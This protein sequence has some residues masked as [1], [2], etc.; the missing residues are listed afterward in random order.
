MRFATGVRLA[1]ILLF[2]VCALQ[3]TRFRTETAITQ[4]LPEGESRDKMALAGLIRATSFTRGMILDVQLPEGGESDAAVAFSDR[5]A[6]SLM[7]SGLFVGVTN[8]ADE[9]TAE[10]FHGIYFPRRYGLLADQPEQEIG[11]LFGDEGLTRSMRT[12]RDQ[13][14]LPSGLMLKRLADD[15]PTLAFPAL[16]Q[17]LE[18]L[19]ARTAP[20]IHCGRFFSPDHHHLLLLA[21]TRA[22][23]FD[24][25]EQRRA[26]DT[27]HRSFDS[28]D[29][30]MGGGY[31]LTFTG[32]NRFALESETRIRRDVMWASIAATIGVLALFALFFRR[33]RLLLLCASPL[34]F[35]VVIA[36]GV[37]L[38]LFGAIHGLTLAFGTTLLGVC[39]DYP[40]H[41]LNHI[42]MRGEGSGHRRS[43]RR[44]H[45]SLA[46]GAVTTLAGYLVISLSSFPGVRQIAVFS[47]AGIV[48]AFAFTMAFVPPVA[49]SM[50][51]GEAPSLGGW[52]ARAGAWRSVGRARVALA[53]VLGLLALASGIAIGAIRAETDPLAFDVADPGTREADE[54]IRGRLPA[55]S[56]PLYVLA[57]GADAEEALQ[58]NEQL[59]RDLDDLVDAG[60]VAR[61]A[62]VRWLLPSRRLQ[63][64]NVQAIVA[65]DGLEARA[66]SAMEAA[67]FLPDSFAG[68]FE[69]MGRLRAGEIDP[70]TPELL[71]DSPLGQMVGGFLV[72]FQGRSHVLTLVEP[73]QPGDDLTAVLPP[74]G[75]LVRFSGMAMASAVM[76]DTQR[77]IAVLGV[78]GLALNLVILALYR[79]RAAGIATTLLPATLAIIVVLGLIGLT[80]TPLTF[81]HVV[82]LLL[83]LSSGVDYAVFLS[84]SRRSA[85]GEDVAI[86]SISVTFSAATTT[87]VFGVLAVCQTPALRILGLTVGGGI[88]LACVFAFAI[89]ALLPEQTDG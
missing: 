56:F 26:I 29:A 28:L 23:A 60:H 10:A 30:D 33:M 5:L 32:L 8:G 20:H 71:A 69:A 34:L 52:M 35:G 48:S 47:A 88:L 12:L 83:V 51:H 84:D 49:R 2:V 67:G 89:N 21:E 39:I 85:S 70:V 43:R 11:E 46:I 58:R 14:A 17:R 3:L 73:A 40:V 15:D 27:L 38:A 66:R 86:A 13:L 63:E 18:A 65:V 77:Q 55:A 81:L 74:A 9:G 59:S 45:A 36:M 24:T 7:D 75:H 22:D 4:F 62:S 72:T 87:L 76:T 61:Y 57:S 44:L 41:L 78:I 53:A 68:F 37:T 64:R 79:R 1:L 42:R 54:A 31:E 16:L 19:R 82:A 6:S 80:G 50:L 25:V